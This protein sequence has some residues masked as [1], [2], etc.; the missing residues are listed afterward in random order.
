[1]ISSATVSSTGLGA[2]HFREDG[3]EAPGHWLGKGSE[4][5]NLK[6]EVNKED[7]QKVARGFS[8]SGT[9]IKQKRSRYI[10]GKIFDGNRAGTDS[11]FSPPKSVSILGLV[12]KD[13]RVVEAHRHAVEATLVEME[14]TCAIAKVRTGGKR[15]NE[16]TGNMIIAAFDHTTS[17]PS[18]EGFADPQI[19]THAISFNSTKC[20]DGKWRS[21]ENWK[22]FNKDKRRLRRFYI[23]ELSTRL[24]EMG[25]SLKHEQ[26][27]MHFSIDGI[28]REQ[29]LAYSNRTRQIEEELGASVK[30]FKFAARRVAALKSRFKKTDVPQ[31]DLEKHWDKVAE[32]NGIDFDSIPGYIKTPPTVDIGM[33]ARLQLRVLQAIET[34]R[35]RGEK[36]VSEAIENKIKQ[37]VAKAIEA[38]SKRFGRVTKA[39]M[40]SVTDADVM[41]FIRPSHLSQEHW[42]ELVNESGIK[43]T[44]ASRSF[45]TV[46]GD[47]A[48]ELVIGHALS[49]VGAHG[50]QHA[51]GETKR[52]LD[53]YK[54]LEHGGLWC[55]GAGEWGELKAN[56]QR[57]R[58][59]KGRDGD[60][61][62]DADGQPAREPVKYDPVYKMDKG[63]T[64]P[65]SNEWHW[66]A[67]SKDTSIAIGIT[68]G[69]KKAASTSSQGL[70]C[71]GIAGLTGGVKDGELN[72]ELKKFEWRGR[73]VYLVLDKDP[74][75]KRDVQ[76]NASIELFKMAAL[77]EKEGATV[78][79]GVIPGPADQKV[80][81]DDHF[82]AGGNLADIKW[83]SLNEFV[84]TS[85]HLPQKYRKMNVKRLKL[86][87]GNPDEL[88]YVAEDTVDSESG[89]KGSNK[90]ITLADD[91]GSDGDDPVVDA[92]P[93]VPVNRCPEIARDLQPT[94]RSTTIYPAPSPAD[95]LKKKNGPR[96]SS[97]GNTDGDTSGSWNCNGDRK[98]AA[99]SKPGTKQTHQ[100]PADPA[101]K[102]P[103]RRSKAASKAR[104][105]RSKSRKNKSD[106]FE[107]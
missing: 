92:T 95:S 83:Q 58:A 60:Y 63:I 17:R 7:L 79:I 98:P 29:E 74:H 36:V 22:F 16:F 62:R 24:V 107:R 84:E 26:E 71:V 94:E 13:K 12:G 20:Q 87:L 54:D 55:K 39:E 102:K 88:P 90:T 34:I 49:K 18:K 104:T 6:G 47:D 52:I 85:P 73:K 103:V 68:E 69:A 19:H 100:Q 75:H 40:D 25:Y 66:D 64:L 3:T 43:P 27:N 72:H 2:Y 32:D 50:Q 4:A 21:L 38:H 46:D 5:L 51:T 99:K 31:V 81:M 105:P 76:R 65:Q 89:D 8:P 9:P 10:S 82:V 97:E 106:G 86:G 70:P 23:K 11:T 1:M 67:I 101:R 91:E 53:T 93:D 80:G 45:E 30:G 14:K 59:K 15:R 42:H 77:L 35:S 37:P 48:K 96:G 78:T 56:V 57:M 28:S 33:K 61:K 41:E 44:I